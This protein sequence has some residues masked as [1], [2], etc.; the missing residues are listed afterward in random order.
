MDRIKLALGRDKWQA[1]VKL[2]GFHKMRGIRW[3]PE[4]LFS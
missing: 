3:L 2:P 4:A 1:I